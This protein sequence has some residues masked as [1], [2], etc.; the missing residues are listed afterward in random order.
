[1]ETTIIETIEEFTAN[2][3]DLEE[4]YFYRGLSNAEDFK[5]IPSAGRYGIKDKDNQVQFERFML[6][7]FKRK[8][9]LNILTKPTTTLEWMFLAQH[10]GLPTRLMDWT[11]NPLVALHFAIENDYDK[12]CAIFLSYPSKGI[13]ADSVSDPF[14]FQETYH[15]V[16]NL[17]HVRYQN[18]NGL[19]TIHPDPNEEDLSK[20]MKKWIIP[21]TFK[22]SM[23]WKLRKLGITKSLLF[24]GLDSVAYDIKQISFN[25]M[26]HLFNE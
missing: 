19:F 2:I 8:A 11:Y 16:P 17:D 14:I 21:K 20:V 5:L 4:T 23:R 22:S 10:H 12:D 3:T 13:L 6:E 15:V 1:M 24:P 9:S 26:G 25:K 18:Q 7:D